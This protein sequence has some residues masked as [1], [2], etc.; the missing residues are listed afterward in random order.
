MCNFNWL[1][2]CY[3]NG[4]SYNRACKSALLPTLRSIYDAETNAEIN[5]VDF[6]KSCLQID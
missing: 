3:S 6:L 5:G 1:V 2:S 4:F